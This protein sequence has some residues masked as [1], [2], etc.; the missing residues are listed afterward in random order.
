MLVFDCFRLC[1]FV[2][3]QNKIWCKRVLYKQNGGLLLD[4]EISSEEVSIEK[5]KI[6]TYKELNKAIDNFNLNW[7]LNQGGQGKA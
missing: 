1:K 7:V 4:Q 3:K 6:F 2:K 5:T